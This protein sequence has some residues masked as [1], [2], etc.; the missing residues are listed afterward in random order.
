MGY[1]MK[2][3]KKYKFNT[4]QEYVNSSDETVQR[5]VSALQSH[6]NG[7]TLDS[8]AQVAGISRTSAVCFARAM[9]QVKLLY[10]CGWDLD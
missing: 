9:R 7:I 2:I 6:K 1:A 5:L 4:M 3:P 8:L 10:I